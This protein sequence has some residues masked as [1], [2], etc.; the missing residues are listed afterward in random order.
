MEKRSKVKFFI[1]LAII[2][3]SVVIVS[4]FSIFEYNKSK[5]RFVI[6]KETESESF[7]YIDNINSET[8]IKQNIYCEYNGLEMIEIGFNTLNNESLYGQA[9]IS[10]K[11]LGTNEILKEETVLYNSLRNTSKY[12]FKIEKQKNSKDKYYELNIKF[13]EDEK[14]NKVFT[15][16]Y[17]NSKE[18]K[19]FYVNNTEN[20]GSLDLTSYYSN[21]TKNVFYY[22][23]M[24]SVGLV[25]LGISIYIFSSKKIT[26]EKAF[27][28]TV[29]IIA[30]LFMFCMPSMKNHDELYH[31][32][33]IC[34]ISNGHLIAGFP[35]EEIPFTSAHIKENELE[36]LGNKNWVNLGYKDIYELYQ[37]N[38]QGSELVYTDIATSAVYAPIQYLP[39]SI[40]L[41]LAKLITNNA[42]VMSY[43]VRLF[44]VVFSIII[45]YLAIKITPFGKKILLFVSYIPIALEGFTSMSPDAITISIA[46][47][48]IAYVL[49]LAFNDE[50]KEIRT[51]EKV[52][53]GVLASVIAL[54][55]IVYVP[56]VFI[57]F[58]IP[59][60]KFKN[61]KDKII[62]LSAVSI[63]AVVL[64]FIWLIIASK[65]VAEFRGGDSKLQLIQIISNPIN[66]LNVLINTINI[67]GY[68]YINSL[69]GGQLGWG[70][71]VN[72]RFIVPFALF[73]EIL[74]IG[75]A[76]NSIKNRFKPVQMAV[77]CIISLIITG[78]IFTSLYIQ[79][80]SVG[81]D[82]IEGVQGRYFLPILPLLILPF[83]YL[84]IESKYKDINITRFIA[85]MG[86]ILNIYT[87]SCLLVAHI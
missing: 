3:L 13:A 84:K 4:A 58:I 30:I 53:L 80:T 8:E 57:I 7:N 12:K 35:N 86:T 38:N 61:K 36:I 1:G 52:I 31:W 5:N 17:D 23:I 15:I 20:T 42:I 70:E 59:W 43:F 19:R 56:I 54:C 67:N 34:D 41:V 66:Y 44:N 68:S 85:I 62:S 72:L 21:K 37:N 9:T 83:A 28:I 48:L 40:G 64:N 75:I 87:I 6:C 50:V 18:D 24:L 16:N 65:Y 2:I 46:F 22:T 47:L 14:N 81:N 77:I 78:L 82:I 51:K 79:W 55:K 11:D 60:Q 76:D 63:I 49:R 69:F 32:F 27:L 10:L 73:I 33:R 25:F 74:F 71:L 29:P 26:E 39:Q 45:L